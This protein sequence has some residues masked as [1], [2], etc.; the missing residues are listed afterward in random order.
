M[1][2]IPRV[3]ISF[4]SSPHWRAWL[5]LLLRFAMPLSPNWLICADFLFFPPEY[6]EELMG[7]TDPHLSNFLSLG[8]DKGTL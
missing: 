7:E 8:A 5:G 2:P 6:S 3:G 4:P 1:Y